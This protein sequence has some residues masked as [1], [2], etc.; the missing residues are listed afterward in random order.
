MTTELWGTF[1]VNDHRRRR[2]FVADVLL[3]DRLAIPIPD[4]KDE[5]KRW[6][7]QGRD[8]A[9]QARLIKKLGTRAVPIP[10][11]PYLHDAWF[12]E[13]RKAL[14]NQP[15]ERVG[16][17]KR[18]RFAHAVSDD[19]RSISDG[20]NRGMDLDSLAQGVTR[21][22]LA[23]SGDFEKNKRQIAGLPKVPVESVAAY[24]SYHHFA[25]RQPYE[26]TSE[27][28]PAGRPMLMFEWPF[29]VPSDSRL[30]DDT[31]LGQAVEMATAK[32]TKQ[33]RDAFHAWRRDMV[34]S[35]VSGPQA[36]E[37][38]ND[39]A[40]D[41]RR[42][43]RKTKIRQRSRYG[44]GIFSAAAGVAALAFPPAGA[45]AAVA[46]LGTAVL[47]AEDQEF[48]QALMAGAFLHEARR[49]LGGR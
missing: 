13:Y 6:E 17:T 26:L 22:V 3:Y 25:S 45:A 4:G 32:Q 28:T 49:R 44:L 31:L 24:G 1:S 36:M 38:L 37:R 12:R 8:P 18:A 14:K 21:G 43:M 30:D 40:A 47:K 34:L 15:P 35:G 7:Q 46:A 42:E 2:A 20:K 23:L 41:Y 27:P 9:R 5:V 16:G 11:T 33:Y 10:W 48:D 29:I 39:L 19:T